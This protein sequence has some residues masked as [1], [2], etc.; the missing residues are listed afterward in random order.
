MLFHRMVV[1]NW[2]NLSNVAFFAICEIFRSSKGAWLEWPNGKYAC[3]FCYLC[4]C[5]GKLS[6]GRRIVNPLTP[7]VNMDINIA[8]KHTVPDRVKP[9]FVIFDIRDWASECPD[10]TNYK[11]RLKPVWHRMFYSCIHMATV[12]VKGLNIMSL[13]FTS[14]HARWNCW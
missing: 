11:W 8:V 10:V 3:L 14:W 2:G 13:R 6:R 1:E 4:H 7:T 9:S 12:G 5:Q